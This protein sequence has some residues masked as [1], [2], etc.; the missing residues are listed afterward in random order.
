MA[1]NGQLLERFLNG[2]ALLPAEKQQ[3]VRAVDEWDAV[4]LQVQGVVSGG[5]GLETPMIFDPNWRTSPLHAFTCLLPTDTSTVDNTYKVLTWDSGVG[6]TSIFDFWQSDKSKVRID[7]A[8]VNIRFD[9]TINW[10]ANATGFREAM[11]DVYDKN[12]VLLNSQLLHKLP[13]VSGNITSV[14]FAV[15]F[16]ILTFLPNA[17]YV[18]LKVAQN[19]GGNLLM[20]NAIMTLSVA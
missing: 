14:P 7:K 15:T 1:T 3:L 20:T 9:G 2:D 12:D 17:V 19:S 5:V 6:D 4:R 13:A 10:E 11:L 18:K 8:Q 16:N